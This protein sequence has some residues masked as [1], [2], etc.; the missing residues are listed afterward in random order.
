MT[1]CILVNVI[2]PNVPHA[3]LPHTASEKYSIVVFYKTK[4]S[5]QVVVVQ[6]FT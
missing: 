5:T 3:P 6:P 2:V 1:V 4:G